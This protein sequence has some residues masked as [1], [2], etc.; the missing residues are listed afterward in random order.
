ML[1]PHRLPRMPSLLLKSACKDRLG[2]RQLHVFL[3]RKSLAGAKRP[4]AVP[5]A[6][7]V[8]AAPAGVD[9]HPTARPSD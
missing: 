5:V 6:A 4:K 7:A 1:L 3:W 2:F 9:M 8:A